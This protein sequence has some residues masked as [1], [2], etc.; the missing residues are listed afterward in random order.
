LS[1]IL[2]G[3]SIL[4]FKQ[5]SCT[6]G[7]YSQQGAIVF[8]LDVSLLPFTH[9]QLYSALSAVRELQLMLVILDILDWG[10]LVVGLTNANI[11]SFLERISLVPITINPGGNI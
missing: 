6:I 11:T 3:W 1:I 10:G 9:E 4:K 5:L 8:T 2:T 7:E